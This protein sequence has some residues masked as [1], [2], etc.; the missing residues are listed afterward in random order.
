[1]VGRLVCGAGSGLRHRGLQVS[2]RELGVGT[3][4]SWA[5]IHE[6][7]DHLS[8]PASDEWVFLRWTSGSPVPVSGW[9]FEN[10]VTGGGR[11]QSF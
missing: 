4:D 5:H 9:L 7:D 2:S 10:F 6:I 11:D 8:K 1:M 3:V